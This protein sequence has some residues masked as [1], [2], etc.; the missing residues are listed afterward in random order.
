MERLIKHA[1][2]TLQH[3]TIFEN[4]ILI[5]ESGYIKPCNE[6]DNNLNSNSLDLN[7]VY[8]SKNSGYE[9]ATEKILSSNYHIGL[10]MNISVNED[11]LLPSYD[12]IEY[13]FPN[14]D[15]DEEYYSYQNGD[16]F[17]AKDYKNLTWKDTL[18]LN[19]EC[20]HNGS[21]SINN[22]I[23]VN[24]FT[25]NIELKNKYSEFFDKKLSLEK[26]KELLLIIK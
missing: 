5:C 20:R 1:N 3:S 22:I 13:V 21:I 16:K 9:F 12:F 2:I 10:Y 17:Y 14:I 19:D 8:L 7:S 23:N 15:G 6:I 11:N 4:F 24:F 26:S 18:D 25:D